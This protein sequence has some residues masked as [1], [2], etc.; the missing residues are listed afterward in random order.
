MEILIIRLI[1]SL[2]FPPGLMIAIMLA[3]AILMR[4]YYRPGKIVIISGFVLLVL[5]S[6]PI[7]P[8]TIIH[9]L[10]D[11]PALNQAELSQPQ[12]QAIVVLGG[13]RYADA[14]EYAGDTV[15]TGSLERI[16]YGAYLHQQ[17][18]LPILVT[19]GNPYGRKISEAE[20]MQTTLENEFKVKVRWAEKASKN[21][22]ENASF[23]FRLLQQE[24]IKKIYLVTHAWHMPRSQQVFEQAGFEV[25]PAPTA[26]TTAAAPILLRLL[27]SAGGLERSRL[28]G[29]ELL[30]MLWYKLRY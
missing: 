21:T 8:N 15:S 6:L 11:I 20:L 7:V 17:T 26:Y 4:F 27:P 18:G 28:V 9:L 12:A 29:H 13:G 1:E 14:P 19:G 30:G 24:N 22:W 23:S 16:R 25:I 10:E 2:L 5:A 3:G